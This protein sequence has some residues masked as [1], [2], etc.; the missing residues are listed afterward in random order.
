MIIEK[1][2]PF[3]ICDSLRDY[4]IDLE[5]SDIC[6]VS[7]SQIF[8]SSPEMEDLKIRCSAYSTIH[9][10]YGNSQKYFKFKIFEIKIKWNSLRKKK[11]EYGE[12]L[13]SAIKRIEFGGS[14]LKCFYDDEYYRMDESR[15][16]FLYENVDSK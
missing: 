11:N 13:N 8:W 6:S 7:V 4:F 15:I 9:R 5:D 1:F 2:E 14:P 3:V 16:Y 10:K 12:I